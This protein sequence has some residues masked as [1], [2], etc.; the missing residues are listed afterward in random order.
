M[1][2]KLFAWMLALAFTLSLCGCGGSTSS[3]GGGRAAEKNASFAAMDAAAEDG[4]YYDEVAEMDADG[5][6]G[7]SDAGQSSAYKNAK[8]KLIRRATVR[9]ETKEFDAAVRGLE[10]LV[11]ELD[12]YIESSSLNQGGYG[13]TYR[14]ASYTVRVPS[15]KYSDFLTRVS[16]EEHCH[17]TSK[18]ESTEDV[19]QQYFDT[20]TRLKTLRTKLERLQELLAQ[21][22][23]MDDIITLEDAISSTEYEID[24]YSSTLNRYDSLIGYSTFNVT[25]EQV[26]TIS[27]TD[28]ISF[29]QRL[30]NS[31]M[32]GLENFIDA[33][34]EFLVWLVGNVFGIALFVVVI[35]VIRFLFRRRKEKRDKKLREM[36]IDPNAPRTSGWKRHNLRRVP[37]GPVAPPP[38][39]KQAEDTAVQQPGTPPAEA[40]AAETEESKEP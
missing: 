40:G 37:P 17:L 22:K 39:G 23:H 4:Y 27:D 10:S 2:R 36:G 12:G 6:S 15:G 33:I 8:V 16:S 31:F 11:N 5:D 30:G 14:S 19:G 9:L 38:A 20:E 35:L 13:S 26:V 32:G 7:N 24:N 25:I 34:Q 3:A 21:A 29:A 28:T 1:K 18:D